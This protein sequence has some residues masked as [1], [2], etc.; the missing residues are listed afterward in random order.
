MTGA[1]RLSMASPMDEPTDMV[2][3]SVDTF[4][5]TVTLTGAV[6]TETQKDSAGTIAGS[7]YG[8][9]GVNNLIVIKKE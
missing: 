5:G 8:V 3:I 1:R 6:Q 4:E 9:R 7:V 2:A